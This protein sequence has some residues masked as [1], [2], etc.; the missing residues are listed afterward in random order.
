MMKSFVCTKWGNNSCH[1]SSF[2]GIWGLKHDESWAKHLGILLLKLNMAKINDFGDRWLNETRKVM[3]ETWWNMVKHGETWNHWNPSL[4]WFFVDAQE[5]CW[6]AG[7]C[8][9]NSVWLQLPAAS[10]GLQLFWCTHASKSNIGPMSYSTPHI[11]NHKSLHDLPPIFGGQSPF[12]L[13]LTH[14]PDPSVF[15][16]NS[17]LVELGATWSNTTTQ[18]TNSASCTPYLQISDWWTKNESQKVWSLKV[19]IKQST[20]CNI[21]IYIC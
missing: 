16:W 10:V 2:L 13:V 18:S 3:G 5:R 15:Y 11:K 6:H 9:P 1:D 4:A 17:W 14:R 20:I 8:R 12:Q 19:V 21:C 7:S